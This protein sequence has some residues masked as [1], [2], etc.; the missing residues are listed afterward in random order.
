MSKARKKKKSARSG[1]TKRVPKHSKI[2]WLNWKK[3]LLI[4][5]LLGAAL[6]LIHVWNLNRLIDQRFEGQT[7]ALPS[8][9]YAR[10]LELF[11]GLQIQPQQ[12]MDELRMAE[13][14]PVEEASNPGLYS[15]HKGELRVYLRE[16]VFADHYQA[17]ALISIRFSGG[18]ITAIEDLSHDKSLDG[19]L[20]EQYKNFSFIGISDKR[21]N[22][23][24]WGKLYK[25]AIMDNII[26]LAPFKYF[27]HK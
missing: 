12:L 26:L 11:K 16:F 24:V 10:P 9:V 5:P 2:R 3:A 23:I 15:F 27:L 22:A 1:H 7:W 8:R 13:Y 18:Q 4:L 21:I 17:A 25:F 6:L 14:R 19:I 20:I